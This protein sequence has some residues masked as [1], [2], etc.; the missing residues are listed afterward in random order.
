MTSVS[1]TF[2]G[3]N[4]VLSLHP[5]VKVLRKMIAEEKPGARK[6][7]QQIISDVEAVPELLE[8]VADV[9]LLKQHTELVEALLGC[10]FP[11][12]TTSNQGLYA[13]TYPFSSETIYASPGFRKIFLKNG[14][15]INV[16]DRR[17][18]VDISRAS[19]LLAYHVILRRCYSQPVTI[20][21][22][23][24]HPF[25]E[26][27][28][29]LTRYYELKLN[30][31]FVDVICIDESLALP[32]AFSPHN[33]PSLEELQER[34][35]LEKFQ[36]EGLVVI[37]V[38]DV[39]GEQITNEIKT[40]LLNI[41]AFSEAEVFEELQGHMQSL[42][43]L[44]NVRIGITPFFQ[45]ND[46]YLYTETHYRNSLLFK[47]KEVM[48]RQDQVSR[49]CQEVFDR[50][51]GPVLYANLDKVNGQYNEL[52]G[53]YRQLGAKSLLLC[54]LKYK[55]GGLIGLL[56]IMSEQSGKLTYA[57]LSSISPAIELFRLALEK[58]AE[59]LEAQ[60]D[61]T[62]KEH[63][64][65]IQPAVEWKFTEAAFHYLQHQNAELVKMPQI[66]FQDVYPLYGAIDIRNS[67]LERTNS[68]QLD[69][70][71][72][73]TLAKDVLS[74]SCKVIDFPL[75]KET[76]YRIDKYIEAASDTLL[77]DDEMQI[78]D[79]LQIQLDAIFKNLLHLR[80]ELK[81]IINGYF[82][83][84]DAQR[85]VV[86]HHRKEYEDSITRI[87]DVL[88]RFTDQEQKT[89]QEIYP[90]YFE[91][92]ITDGV[93]FNIY[94]GQSL[95][96]HKPFN[97]MF[98]RNLKLWQLT[99]LAKAARV[100]ASLE[101]RLPLPLQTTQLI[102][103]HAIPLSISFRRKE[104]KFDVDGAY[105]IRYEIIKK[106]IDKVHIRD[107]EER[108]TQPGKIAIV[109]SQHKELSEYL[110]YIEF[111]QN[112]GLLG[113]NIE[114]LD[115]EDTQGISGLKAVRVDVNFVTDTGA[116]T[117][118]PFTRLSNVRQA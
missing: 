69:L 71:E 30:A 115:L 52:V 97:E 35:P 96:P 84:L 85:K 63:F 46:Y 95:S 79:F 83:A 39:T 41:N 62:I 59:S 99:F 110:E 19:L 28:T 4:S 74:K 76:Q 31:E 105:N 32:E 70:L 113:E 101:K 10:I 54:P 38:S 45:K 55:D 86:Y 109:Y 90:H 25:T 57:H 80:P 18:T 6:L 16:P 15:T 82:N 58:T 66:A 65:A 44:R 117:K 102:L 2:A 42:I 13:I 20:T 89:V 33:I 108:L 47:N 34:F 111:L 64:T 40:A 72:Q 5:L 60:I 26:E 77:S 7:Y 53:Y 14:S 103:A 112:E 104:R 73:L 92:Y 91:R 100:T 37:N 27:G 51:E 87:N 68:I 21:A 29:E 12:S 61:K 114:H 106:R 116:T 56:E 24:V 9:S 118:E 107:S 43:G 3:F 8:P 36:F 98:V 78:Y 48:S 88:D 93:E 23:T 94:V 75:L 81:K 1:L 11:P 50:V 22:T 17:T 49:L 67:S